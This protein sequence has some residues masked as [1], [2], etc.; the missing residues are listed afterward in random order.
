MT[1]F[2]QLRYFVAV[3]REMHF[4]RAAERL[5]VAQPSL[6]LAI[7]QLEQGLGVALFERT[8]RSVKLTPAGQV[9]YEEA[10]RTL[11]QMDQACRAAQRTARGE[12]GR[13]TLGFTITAIMGDLHR[14]IQVFRQRHPTVELVLHELLVD[15]LVEQLETGDLDLICTDAEVV[16]ETVQCQPM[17]SPPWG[18]AI[19]RNNPLARRR[20]IDLSDVARE[21]FIIATQYPHHNLHE[22]MINVCR[23]AGF[24]PDVRG[25]AHSVPSCLS[26]VAANLGVAMAYRLP[27]YLPPD[28]VYRPMDGHPMDLAMQ[29]SWRRGAL[30]PAAEKFVQL[31][32]AA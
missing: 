13:L 16:D 9:F 7:R 19:N 32:P 15:A 23:T 3:A 31:V 10:V 18:L 29:M 22:K 20:S 12:Q 14:L 11:E 17:R 6:S 1:D 30:T 4:R 21:P 5:H 25:Y 26:M 2:R 24:T 8:S 27:G 28:I